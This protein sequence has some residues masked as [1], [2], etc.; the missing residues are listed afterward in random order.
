[1]SEVFKL[2]D[3]P[4]DDRAKIVVMAMDWLQDSIKHNIEHDSIS[5]KLC[6]GISQH[7]LYN[8]KLIE[9]IKYLKKTRKSH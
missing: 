1:M 6:L 5:C 4:I 2:E 7:L 8:H 3:L 9:R